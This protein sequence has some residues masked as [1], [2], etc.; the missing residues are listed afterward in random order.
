[1]NWNRFEAEVLFLNPNDAP[2]AVA[3]LAAVDCEFEIDHDAIE[4]DSV[5]IFGWVTGITEVGENDI[6]AWL[7]TTVV[8]RFGGDVI[9]WR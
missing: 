3:A 1:M 2:R 9:Q 6:G 5:T 7:Y 8:A 4:D